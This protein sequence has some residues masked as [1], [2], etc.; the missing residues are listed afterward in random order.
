MRALLERLGYAP[1]FELPFLALGRPDLA[2]GRVVEVHAERYTV[3]MAHADC[4]AELTGNLRYS[5]E[6]RAAF[7]T[8]GDWVAAV[9]CGE[10]Q[11]LIH[12]VLPRRSEL[13]RRSVSGRSER[14][15]IAANID[16]ALIVQ[17]A[18]RDFNLNRLERYLTVVYGAAIAPVLL[19]SKTDLASE[20]TLVDLRAAVRARHP[21]LE[22]LGVNCLNPGGLEALAGRIEPGRTYCVL[23]SSGTGKSTLINALLGEERLAT[24]AISDWN[25]R[26]KHTTSF[27]SLIV[28]PQ[29]GILVDTPGMREI[30]GVDGP[31]ALEIVFDDIHTLTQTCHFSDCRHEEEPGCAVRAAIEAGALDPGKLEN[32]RRMER[33]MAHF[34]ASASERRRKARSQ[35][36]MYKRILNEKRQRNTWD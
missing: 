27:R 2:P 9:V 19:L 7:P 15:V 22:V 32:Y 3:R 4:R 1:D 10:E 18:D 28:L 34:E 23:G 12:H 25:Q 11:A 29:G 26:G 33:E 6:E 35:G 21:A 16:V 31:Q 17:S 30:G 5:L 13:A 36:K 24:R 20:S 8:V 14:Q